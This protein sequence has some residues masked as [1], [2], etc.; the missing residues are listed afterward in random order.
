M[1]S[2]AGQVAIGT[3]A[4]K[5]FSAA[6]GAVKNTVA[7]IPEFANAADAIGKQSQTLGL[8]VESLQ[9]FQYAAS[10]SNISN[11]TLE[12]SFST[13]N[14]GMGS[15]AL[16]T[17]LD[18]LDKGLTQQIRGAKS[19]EEAF[20]IISNA[21]AGY[22][23]VAQRTAVLN[24]ALGKSADDMVP[25]LADGADGLREIMALA[26]NI[27]SSR[28]V[29]TATVFGDTLTHINAVIK[30]FGDTAKSG[31][32]SAILPYI[33]AL[34][35]WLDTN[36]ELIKVKIKEFIQGAIG[37]IDKLRPTVMK[38]I[39]TVKNVIDTVRP[40]VTWAIGNLPKL[41][42]I[43]AGVVGAFM[44]F[45]LVKGVIDG[46]TKALNGIK[47]FFSM[48]PMGIIFAVI[49]ALI[50]A[51]I[52]LSEK[53]G[54]WEN[55][56]E[57]VKLTL[58]AVVQTLMKVVL[59]PFNLLLTGV[60][61]ALGLFAEFSGV[62]AIFEAIGQTIMKWLL[63]P[64]NTVIDAIGGLLSVVSKIDPSGMTKGAMEA[65]KN[66]QDKMNIMLTGSASTIGHDGLSA[67]VDPSRNVDANAKALREAALSMQGGVG[68]FQK[69]MN[70]LL[71]GSESTLWNSGLGAFT[72]PFKNADIGGRY[73]E[74]A[75]SVT[76]RTEDNSQWQA[77][78]DKLD[79]VIN[80][81][82]G[83]TAAV[84]GAASVKVKNGAPGLNFAGA[85][86]YDVFSTVRQGI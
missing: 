28:T 29:A 6:W 7:S 68:S 71:T 62:A 80:A 77:I 57:L 42:P 37:V 36:K 12:K 14:K 2:I 65:V 49:A 40:F 51:F 24:A 56:L 41:I 8:G 54:G 33:F 45:S 22:D 38:I 30:D 84:E 64:V 43:V 58:L 4:A 86:S 72:D 48:G 85:G 81:Q 3:L 10:M 13:L 26:P 79:G 59:T 61:A 76:P 60:Q 73:R 69:G 55:A 34:K 52:F 31:I 75:A 53:V 46:V 50:A 17:S 25:M 11:E 9:R 74:M 23:D 66:F 47:M 18:K 19:T 20:M 63:T 82:E 5:G 67:L 78:L 1:N 15:G 44:A 32:M 21:V 35:E 27:L 83:T 16:V 70:K 39:E